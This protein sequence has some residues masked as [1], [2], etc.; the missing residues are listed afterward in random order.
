VEGGRRPL[1]DG[2]NMNILM[3]L[4]ET[5][6]HSLPQR[7]CCSSRGKSYRSVPSISPNIPTGIAISCRAWEVEKYP[8]WYVAMLLW[9]PS[10]HARHRVPEIGNEAR[11][12]YLSRF[13]WRWGSRRYSKPSRVSSCK[14]GRNT[15]ST[16]TGIAD[17]Q[18]LLCRSSQA[19]CLYLG[20]AHG[21]QIMAGAMDRNCPSKFIRYADV[22]E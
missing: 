9:S 15:H 17:D 19:N 13:A 10:R 22:A 12:Q 18:S 16:T 7:Q 11:L 6:A 14:A 3:A 21:F 4:A 1:H 2:S 5:K 20:G 8:L